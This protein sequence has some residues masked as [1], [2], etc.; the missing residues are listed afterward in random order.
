MKT[1]LCKP[2][3]IE[4]KLTLNSIDNKDI[5][6]NYSK[7]CIVKYNIQNYYHM[8]YQLILIS[9]DPDEKIEVGNI[10]YDLESPRLFT[11]AVGE[12]VLF[13]LLKNKAA[14]VIAIQSQLSPE[15]IQQFVEE[16]NKCEIKDV[17]IEMEDWCDYDDDCTWGGLDKADYRIKLTNNFITIVNKEEI[18]EKDYLK[19]K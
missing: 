18:T 19:Q 6:L 15:Y 8:V 12:N 16:Y 5:K 4:S 17:E 9:L 14:K 13:R 10:C 2:V 11:C 7:G 3:L 1:K